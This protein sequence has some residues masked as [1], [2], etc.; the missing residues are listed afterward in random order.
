MLSLIHILGDTNLKGSVALSDYLAVQAN[1][2]GSNTDWS[3][4]N[5]HYG[6]GSNGTGLGDLL[7]T[8]SNLNGTA[9]GNL[10]QTSSVHGNVA[11]RALS[12]SPD[13][14]P[15][16]GANDLQ[17]VVNTATGDVSMVNESTTT[18]AFTAYSI[19]VND[20]NQTTPLL[21]GNPSDAINGEGGTGKP[22][23]THELVLAD[24]NSGGAN[25]N[26]SAAADGS[27]PS[28]WSLVQD[29]ENG[30]GNGFGLAE[31]PLTFTA[32]PGRSAANTVTIPIG[33]AID[34]G[35]TVSYTHLVVLAGSQTL[36]V[37][38]TNTYSG[39]T[40]VNGGTLDLTG[41]L[42]N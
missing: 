17:L 31:A 6:T 34:L 36:T 33:G 20:N 40:T 35:N 27:V 15:I 18:T 25:Y 19:K 16:A 37:A 7:A 1:L 21:V 41:A 9:T 5:F 12:A 39:S 3:Q 32:T 23:F 26:S 30:N 11:T 29:G 13:V 28:S 4:G 22:P 38:T 14:S 42:P 24:T 2:N 10:V 8:Q